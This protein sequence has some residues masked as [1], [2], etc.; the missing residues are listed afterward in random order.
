M[1]TPKEKLIA[2]LIKLI[3]KPTAR[4]FRI[5][6][7]NLNLLDQV[8]ERAELDGGVILKRTLYGNETPSSPSEEIE[9]NVSGPALT[10]R[11]RDLAIHWDQARDASEKRE[12]DERRKKREDFEEKQAE[13]MLKALGIQ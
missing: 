8:G 1:T 7:R 3:Q 10:I 5:S 11:S 12:A 4:F 2:H 13:A 9:V 6:S